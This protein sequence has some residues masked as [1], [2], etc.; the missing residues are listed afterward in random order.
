MCVI[1]ATGCSYGYIVIRAVEDL[2]IIKMLVFHLD[3]YAFLLS[4]SSTTDF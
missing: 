3:Y 1:V 2:C 4:F